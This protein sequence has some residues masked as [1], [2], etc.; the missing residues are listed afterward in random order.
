MSF[1]DSDLAF[2][3]DDGFGFHSRGAA[4]AILAELREH[5]IHDGLVVDLGSGSG[6]WARTLVDAGYDV[7][8]VEFS[9]AMIRL[10]KRRAP[11]A[12]YVHASFFDA[13]IPRCQAVTSLGECIGYRADRS[14]Q[15]SGL[16]QRVYDALAPGGL[17][18]F[19]L[20]E[21]GRGKGRPVWVDHEDWG[22]MFRQEEDA[23]KR[24]LIRYITTFTRDG[25]SFRR[26]REVH[27]LRLYTRSEV[28]GDLRRAGFRAKTLPTYG[29]TP[30]P[31]GLVAYRA[32]KPRA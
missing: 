15:L 21:P 11:E 14:G 4:P 30:W 9:R 32:H 6:I 19:D 16:F 8:G 5:T 28:L 17:F 3:H 13:D 22:I 23:V 20:A 25:K 10:A 2:I 1:Y 12:Q 27:E 31:H 29:Y 26:K 24:T 18:I 7:L